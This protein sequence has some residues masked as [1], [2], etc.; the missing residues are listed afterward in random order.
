[1]IPRRLSI[2]LY[3]TPES[4]A[5]PNLERFIPLFHRF[6][7]QGSVEGLLIDVADYRH[8]PD[9]PGVLLV[10]HDVEYAIDSTGGRLGLLTTRK[11]IDGGTL[12]GLI[13]DTLRRALVAVARIEADGSTGLR[14]ETDAIEVHL[15]DRLAAPNNDRTF[16]TLCDAA[17]PVM[18]RLFGDVALTRE[19]ADDFR[20]PPALRVEA[21][22]SAGLAELIA[23]LEGAAV[24][25]RAPTPAEAAQS[26]WDISVEEL[27]KLRDESEV[28]LLIDVRET[29]EYEVGHLDGTLVPLGT[30]PGRLGEFER[31][32]HIVVHCRSGARSA[33]AVELMRESGFTNVW[34][35]RGGLL[36]WIERIDA[37][38]KVG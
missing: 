2:K 29:H 16:E 34:N 8:V 20:Q 35:V 25:R 28:F 3:A 27:K 32:A 10:G 19:H 36:A 9:G 26:E 37:T 11:R 38:V 31:E 4:A 1:M 30:L 15:L 22:E 33:R 14:F 7:Q 18:R 5:A 12:S 24:A 17:E 21:Q 6:I 23:A 13:A